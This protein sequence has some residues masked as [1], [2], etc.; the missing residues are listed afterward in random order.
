M[1]I[2]IITMHICTTTYSYYND[3]YLYIYTFNNSQ[4]SRGSRPAAPAPSPGRV[5]ELAGALL[6]S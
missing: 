4:L 2:A 6:A 3:T 5:R 1:I